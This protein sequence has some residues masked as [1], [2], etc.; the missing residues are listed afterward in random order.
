MADDI[1]ARAQATLA[2]LRG[3]IDPALDDLHKRI[4]DVAAAVADA[5]RYAG[6]WQDAREYRPGDV[7]THSGAL[8]IAN[9]ETHSRPGQNGDWKLIQKRKF[10]KEDEVDAAWES[11]KQQ[12]AKD[13]HT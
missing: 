10:E 13:A 2:A 5:M 1:E 8:W 11:R 9:R 6:V 3:Y 4:D 7:T 12:R